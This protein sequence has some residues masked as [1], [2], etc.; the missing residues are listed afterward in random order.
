MKPHNQK[1]SSLHKIQNKLNRKPKTKKPL[2][3]YNLK[4]K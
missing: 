1:K 2:K 4:N 3:Q